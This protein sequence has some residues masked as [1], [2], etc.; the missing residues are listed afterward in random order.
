MPRAFLLLVVAQAAHSIEEYVA[1]LYEVF[2]PARF[3]SR[4]ISDDLAT[5]FAVAN[6][7]IV[8][9]GLWCWS[10]PVRAGWPSAR[11]IVWG[12]TLVEL[13]NGTVHAIMA[14]AR[15]GYFPGVITA[16]LL[17]AAAL[18]VARRLRRAGSPL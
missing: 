2:A 7:A 5:G 4:L 14:V 9:F 17:I 12:W 13:G 6:L 16:P 1:R 11:A 10:L 8:A 18:L 3:V 15:G